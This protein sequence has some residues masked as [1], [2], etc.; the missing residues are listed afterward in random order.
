MPPPTSLPTPEPARPAPALLAFAAERLGACEVV[1]ELSWDHGESAVWELRGPGGR[2]VL[3]AHRQ[4]RKFQQELTANRE[5]LPRLAA[6]AQP[7]PPAP[8]ASPA[9][10]APGALPAGPAPAEPPARA[11]ALLAWRAEAPRALLFAFE[12]GALVQDLALTTEHERQVHRRAGAYLAGLHGLDVQDADP[13]PL[14]D[15]FRQRLDAWAERARG[16]VP[17]PVIADVRAA[18][19]EALPGLRRV[20]RRACH[21]D[22]TPRNWLLSPAGELVVIDFEHARPDLYLNDFE[23]LHTDLWRRRPDLREAFLAGYGRELTSEE[24]ELLRRTAA[25]GALS[26]VVWAREHG[27]AAFE[28]HGWRTLAWLGLAG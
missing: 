23:R 3:K 13:V 21:R 27:D 15:A 12:E 4:G 11:P 10:P 26:T 8:E 25:L 17:E 18:A 9:R 2:A 7:A 1:R 16:T 20:A 28:A 14:A 5:W 6:E 24:L 22:Y 19:T